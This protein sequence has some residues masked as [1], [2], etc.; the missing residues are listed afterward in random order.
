ML[1]AGAQDRAHVPAIVL[2]V[3]GCFDAREAVRNIL[4]G[5]TGRSARLAAVLED[6]SDGAEVAIH[7][8][9]A[10]PGESRQPGAELAQ[11]GEC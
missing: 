7:R 9:G 11:L 1:D 10:A 5:K 8:V 4:G 3:D 6:G 2:P